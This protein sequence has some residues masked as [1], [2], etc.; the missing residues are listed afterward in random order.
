M[1]TNA[2]GRGG[3]RS[4]S[5]STRSSYFSGKA[6]NTGWNRTGNWGKQSHTWK[7]KSATASAVPIEYKT[8]YNDFWTKINSYRTLC[9]QT[10]GPAKYG[11]PT[12]ATL[13]TFANWVNKGAVI[14]TVS[15]AQVWRW[16]RTTNKPFN[17]NT[18]NTTAC[19]TVLFAKFGKNTI[20]A[21]AR[22]KTGT[23]MVATSPTVN[24]RPFWFPK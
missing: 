6:S 15:P 23:F 20:K 1:A 13:N 3:Y 21:V 9:N 12:P 24:G 5:T 14:Q 18:R 16:A 4:P 7:G 10:R 19:K 11:R 17:P 2:R 22:T 8:C